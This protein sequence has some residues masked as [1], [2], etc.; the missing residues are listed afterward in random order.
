MVD[1]R[2]CRIRRR[3]ERIDAVYQGLPGVQLVNELTN[4]KIKNKQHLIF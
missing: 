2:G 4:E 1:K 3:P